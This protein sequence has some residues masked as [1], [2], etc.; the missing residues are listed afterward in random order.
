MSTAPHP[1]DALVGEDA[2]AR[3]PGWPEAFLRAMR[4]SAAYQAAR[5]PFYGRLAEARGFTPAR[6]AACE[7]PFDLP[8]VLADV[9][10]RHA[11]DTP[12]GDRVT[13]E[14]RS[15]GTSGERSRILL[16]RTSARRLI[17]ATRAVYASLGLVRPEPA[18]CLLMS[19]D[20][21]TAPELATGNADALVAALTP[22]RERFHALAVGPGGRA[23]FRLDE[24]V[25]ALR[26]FV[27]AGAPVR[28]LGFP[29]HACETIR[30]YARVHG[31]LVLPEHSCLLT[32]GGWKGFAARYAADFDRFAFLAAHTS[33]APS[34]VRDAYSLVEHPISYV[35]CERHR[36]HVPN[37]ADACAR[38]PRSLRRLAHGEAGLLQLVTPLVDSAPN[39]SVLT[40][41]LGEVHPGCDCGRDGPWIRLLGRAG[42]LQRPTCALTASEAVG[43]ALAGRV[44]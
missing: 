29:H 26:A 11:L 41:D 28:I 22:C 23:V 42:R 34:Q 40:T 5:S 39:L 31:R 43:A 9:F 38:D 6:L 33:L 8:W 15:S 37:V 4:W 19:Y 20:V 27:A 21:A 12:T 10:K 17:R 36:L 18:S 13:S 16:D 3:P 2:F 1:V 24:A 25:A 35:E 7:D 14:L 30:E 44:A 32:G